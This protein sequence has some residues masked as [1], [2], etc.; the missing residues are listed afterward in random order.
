VSVSFD[1]MRALQLGLEWLCDAKANGGFEAVSAVNQ[2]GEGWDIELSG[3]ARAV[4][5]N[6]LLLVADGS[7]L[8]VQLRLLLRS[9]ALAG[10]P[11]AIA[12]VEGLL[13]SLDLAQPN[14]LV[15]ASYRPLS[16]AVLDRV[17]A[18][19]VRRHSTAPPLAQCRHCH[20]RGHSTAASAQA[21]QPSAAAH[22]LLLLT[23]GCV[24]AQVRRVVN[25]DVPPDAD[26]KAW[27]RG[28]GIEAMLKIPA[29]KNHLLELRA[30]KEQ[31]AACVARPQPTRSMR[32]RCEP[33]THPPLPPAP[34][35]KLL[36]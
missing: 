10:L 11:S 17:G 26:A 22:D 18:A 5:V 28:E 32:L 25:N 7:R 6:G 2:F 31:K 12:G 34:V 13:E 30:N 9:V 27:E 29:P 15:N 23:G 21:I 14:E 35:R 3:G 24:D 4:I 33:C 8:Q 16:K 19:T 20:R 1:S 36:K